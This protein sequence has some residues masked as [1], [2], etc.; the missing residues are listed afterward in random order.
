M[1]KCNKCFIEK[2]DTLFHKNGIS[3]RRPTCAD[4][5]REYQRD[6]RNSEGSHKEWHKKHPRKYKEYALKHNYGLSLDEYDRLLAEQNNRCAICKEVMDKICVDHDH[7]TG[8]V[9][10]LLCNH[11]N[12]ALGYVKDSVLIIDEMR[13]YLVR[14][15]VGKK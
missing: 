1:K 7:S 9:R 11:C 2:D 6:W 13:K 12:L 8:V 14:E 5:S 10:G 3:G 15:N 4:C